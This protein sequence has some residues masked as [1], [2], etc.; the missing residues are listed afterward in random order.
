MHGCI[1]SGWC[2]NENNY[3]S[4]YTFISH[5]FFYLYISL[6]VVIPIIYFSLFYDCYEKSRN[7]KL[8]YIETNSVV[9]NCV[10]LQVNIM[11][12][13][14]LGIIHYQTLQFQKQKYVAVQK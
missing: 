4:V 2:K 8:S 3:V 14:L 10:M 1:G 12:L 5:I 9:L 13:I 11:K 6:T 7:N